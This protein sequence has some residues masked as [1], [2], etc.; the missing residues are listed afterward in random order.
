MHS[1]AMPHAPVREHL[2]APRAGYV[3]HYDAG[4]IGRAAVL[5][6]A[7]RAKAEDAVDPAVG[8][9]LLAV[10]G[11]R[12]EAG[13]PLIAIHA[14]RTTDA[15]AVRPMLTEALT[16]ADA[17]PPPRP[18]IIDRLGLARSATGAAG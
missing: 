12:V 7:G 4:M 5:L 1:S 14:R 6:G 8:F 10:P 2:V 18:L 15:A 16:M 3:A 13:A 9:E 11:D 17:P